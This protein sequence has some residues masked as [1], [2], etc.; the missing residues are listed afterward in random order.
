MHR[1]LKLAA[2]VLSFAAFAGCHTT[3]TTEGGRMILEEDASAALTRMTT[4]DPSLKPFLDRAYGYVIFPSIGKG[5]L[6]V[7]G[8]YGRG[9]VY[10]GGQAVGYADVTQA[11][12]GL[13][14]GGQ[15]YTQLIAF[16]DLATF[17]AFKANTLT[18]S[19]NA[20]AVAIKAG[21][22]AATQ[23]QNGTAVFTDSESGLMGEA[24]VGG[25]QLR[26]QPR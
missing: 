23:F 5:G 16:E 26:Y 12:I 25:Q 2:L 20:S 17:N 14:I 3:P 8:A 19:A 1:S 4:R 18:F 7:G 6:G 13:Q 24:T 22:G 21:A 9:V 11:T 10:Q 15:A